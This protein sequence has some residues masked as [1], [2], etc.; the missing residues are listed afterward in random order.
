MFFL[1]KE[2]GLDLT[3]LHEGDLS[4]RSRSTSREVFFLLEILSHEVSDGKLFKPLF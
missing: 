2:N 4:S 3:A 1:A